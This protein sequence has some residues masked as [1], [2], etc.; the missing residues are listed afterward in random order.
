MHSGRLIVRNIGFDIREKHLRKEFQRYGPIAEVNVPMKSGDGNLNRG[1]AFIEFERKEEAT[2]AI[3]AMNQKKWKGRT[4]ALE[5]SQAKGVYESKVEKIV[6]HTNL[7][8][9]EAILPKVLREERKEQEKK[10]EELREQREK[11]AALKEKLEKIR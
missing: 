10:K 5:L 6:E 3:S 4:V 9:E 8:R 11:E 2:A 7:N 1:F